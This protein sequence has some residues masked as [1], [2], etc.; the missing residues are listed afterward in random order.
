M[1][2][3]RALMEV[4]LTPH[5]ATKLALEA[6]QNEVEKLKAELENK[7]VEM[8][9]KLETREPMI[10]MLRT[11]FLLCGQLQLQ[12]QT[13]ILK[14]KGTVRELQALGFSLKEAIRIAQQNRRLALG[15]KNV[16]FRTISN[17][18]LFY[19]FSDHHLHK[20]CG[21]RQIL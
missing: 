16:C 11:C 17:W 7:K 4:G 8:A 12:L 14:T 21:I 20:I 3:F 18:T 9:V 5:Q 13:M 19:I 10:G 15:G 1:A 2:S 6:S